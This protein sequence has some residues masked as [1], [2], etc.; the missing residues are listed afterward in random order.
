MTAWGPG[1][2]VIL[3][4]Q[5]THEALRRYL[6]PSQFPGLT[7]TSTRRSCCQQASLDS[8]HFGRVSPKAPMRIRDA[9]M[10]LATTA[11]ATASARRALS[12]WLYGGVP[13]GSV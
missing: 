8:V 1:V 5:P 2:P 6:L 11:A 4:D 3:G 10:P 13:R 9:G 12:F 7:S